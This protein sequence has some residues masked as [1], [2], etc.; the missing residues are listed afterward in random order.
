MKKLILALSACAAAFAFTACSHNRNKAEKIETK[1]EDTQAITGDENVGIKDGNMIVQKKVL[2]NDELRRIQNEVYSLEDRVYG[3]RKYGSEGLYGTLKQ[4]RTK[5][6]SKSM[7]G[8]GKVQYTEPMDRITD[9]EDEWKVG[10]DEK[11]KL[12]G[13]SE[14]F[15]MDRIERFKNYKATLMKREDEYKEKVEV[16][17]ADLAA[18]EEEMK[19]KKKSASNDT[20]DT[21]G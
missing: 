14:E 13:V 4:C 11:K 9:K 8:T 17:D 10:I 5:L 21:E 18:R 19:A 6:N 7:G 15:L 12:V 20:T 2:M 1:M 3:S 16:C